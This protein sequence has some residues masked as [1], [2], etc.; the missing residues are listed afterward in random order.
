MALILI[1]GLEKR[2][3]A[4]RAVAALTLD[5][6]DREF[7]TLL[8]PS[9]CGK[10]TTLRLLAGFVKPDA[11]EIIVDGRVL[12]SPRT[13]VPPER[14]HMGMVFQSYALWPHMTVFENI[15]FG[16]SLKR[17]RH[18]ETRE[19]VERVLAMVGLEGLGS[20]SPA[21]LSGGQQQRVALARSLV[22]EP[23]ILLLDEPLSNLDA[24]LRERMRGELKDLQR[25]TGI[26]FV[27]VTHD[28]TEA[29]VMSDRIA[30]LHQGVL[31]QYGPPREIYERP[32][33]RFIADFMGAVNLLEAVVETS[34]APGELGDVTAGGLRLRALLPPRTAA[35]DRVTV[36][37]RPEDIAVSRTA[38]VA[39]E[40]VLRG[41]ISDGAFLGSLVDY[42]V[43]V[44]GVALRVQTPRAQAYTAGEDVYLWIDPHRCVAVA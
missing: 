1:T 9:G 26:T 30:V 32:A 24:K 3:G 35:G 10:T 41:V 33:S 38:P 11:G 39:A 16:L 36:T 27:Y 18:K 2:F 31:Q 17:V 5:V 25:R 7:V 4:R 8:G 12:S 15:A 42:R 21:T 6:R 23:S 28:Q 40:N 13:L 34:A 19:R 29:L 43:D 20:Q 37:V 22:T 14:R 44:G